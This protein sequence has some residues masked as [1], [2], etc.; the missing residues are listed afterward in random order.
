MEDQISLTQTLV[1]RK[2]FRSCGK[3]IEPAELWKAGE[4]TA[5]LSA[6]SQQLSAS[7]LRAA[8]PRKWLLDQGAPADS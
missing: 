6:F 3:P 1:F 4:Y 2:I 5:E 8:F 7:L